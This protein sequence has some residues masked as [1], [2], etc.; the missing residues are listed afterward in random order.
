MSSVSLFFKVKYCTFNGYTALSRLSLFSPPMAAAL[1]P[2]Q[3]ELAE[4]QHIFDSY[5]TDKSGDIDASEL[6]FVFRGLGFELNKEELCEL[7][8]AADDNANGVIDFE[9]FVAIVAHHKSSL[10]QK[11]ER[12]LAYTFKERK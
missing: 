10:S 5:D 7:V 4:I 8:M 1:P 3:E 12:R 6:K 11:N 2:S 9:E